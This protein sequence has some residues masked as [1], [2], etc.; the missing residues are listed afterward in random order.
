ML[1]SLLS[2]YLSL[3]QVV[4]KLN[5]RGEIGYGVVMG[6]DVVHGH[7]LL[8]NE[9]KVLIEVLFGHEIVHPLYGYEMC[10]SGFAQWPT[11]DLEL[12]H[13]L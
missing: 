1:H 8:Q 7:T 6:G 13:D 12:Y 9:T 2:N 3:F 10:P 11:Q 5:G 4:L